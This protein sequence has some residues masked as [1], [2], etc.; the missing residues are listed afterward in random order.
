MSSGVAAAVAEVGG[1]SADS[2]P[3]HI[4]PLSRLNGSISHSQGQISAA[5][6]GG[7][8]GRQEPTKQNSVGESIPYTQRCAVLAEGAVSPQ[9]ANQEL[10]GEW[11]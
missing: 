2:V 9:L 5:H 7:T 8:M 4:K 6:S 11:T 3:S 1:Y 10:P